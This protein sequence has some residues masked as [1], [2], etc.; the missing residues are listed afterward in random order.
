MEKKCIFAR[1]KN[2]NSKRKMEKIIRYLIITLIL[3]LNTVMANGDNR[4]ECD[5]YRKEIA[6]VDSASVQSYIAQ[7]NKQR[8]ANQ[9]AQQTL[10]NN[11]QRNILMTSIVA[12]GLLVTALLAMGLIMLRR[13]NRRLRESEERLNDARRMVE[14]SVRLKNLFLS[15]MSHEIRTPLNALAGFS[16]ILADESLDDESRKQ[17]ECIIQQNSDLLMKLI[18]DV[19]DFS[20]QQNGE[21]QFRMQRHD[22]V[23]ICRN[24]VKT[25]DKVKQTKATISFTS[26]LDS[27]PVT[28]T[29]PACSSCSSTCW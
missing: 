26:D 18:N 12:G 5:R 9:V 23:E 19:V 8:A 27:L 17:F 14:N 15:N 28:T 2:C 3:L 13:Y 6:T 16:A 22:A 20:N 11:H 29:R 1:E 10:R 4:T 24:V 7:V 21:M 25:V